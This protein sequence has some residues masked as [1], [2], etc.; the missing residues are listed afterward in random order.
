MR[1]IV[2]LSVVLVCVAAA[3]DGA[4]APGGALG[5]V[6]VSSG[7][8][9][10]VISPHPD[11]GVLGAGGLIQRIVARHG[12]VEIVEM[13][14]GDAF[15]KGVAALRH[16]TTPPSPDA[17][18]WY[19]TLREHEAVRAM[20]QLGVARS[21]V[22]LLGFPDEGLCQLADDHGADVVFASPYTRR[23]SP[24]GTERVLAD[25]KYRGADTRKELEDL[26]VAFRPNLV[27]VPDAHDEHP[28]HC[29]THLLVHDAVAG[30]VS[31]GV[32]PPTVWHYLIHY[33][34]WPS[35]PARFPAQ[36][37]F[38]TLKLSSAER[39]GKHQALHAYRTQQTV[40]PEFLAA[41][42][43]AEERFIVGENETPAACWCGGKNIA[44][45]S[46]SSR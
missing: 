45:P 23:D 28:D 44:P 5:T 40:M 37:A 42:D 3:A 7:T 4:A 9:A 27:V 25:T 18:R 36:D 35:D 14:S 2:R 39:A 41:F 33:R 1:A 31:R 22:R 8:R 30:A 16:A 26:F 13:T 10:I 21:R 6:R 32:R 46:L 17:Y 24:P 19:G 29:A 43:R 15:P 12:S 11:D 20:K 38:R 34:T